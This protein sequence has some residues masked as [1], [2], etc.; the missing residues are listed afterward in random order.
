MK[1]VCQLKADGRL[2]LLTNAGCLVIVE[3]NKIIILI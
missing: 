1:A 2:R 3:N